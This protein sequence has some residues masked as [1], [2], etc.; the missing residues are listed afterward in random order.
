[1]WAERV[2]FKAFIQ[3]LCVSIDSGS[4]SIRVNP[5]YLNATASPLISILPK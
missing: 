1:M 4:Q 2:L 5:I 3:R